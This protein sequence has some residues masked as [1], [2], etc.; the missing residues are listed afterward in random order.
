M[1]GQIIGYVVLSII[2]GLLIQTNVLLGVFA[3][4]EALSKD[5]YMY[6]LGMSMLISFVLIGSLLL[7]TS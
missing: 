6:S 4:E 3:D 7:I 2:F 1:A 5:D